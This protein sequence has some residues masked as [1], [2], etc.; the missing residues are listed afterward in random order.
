MSESSLCLPVPV[1]MDSP[2]RSSGPPTFIRDGSIVL[3][4]DFTVCREGDKL[5]DKA[6]QILRQFGHKSSRLVSERNKNVLF[7]FLPNSDRFELAGRGL[8]K[9]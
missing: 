6:A 8:F 4:R 7:W 2:L 9:K 5:N 3:D 1:A